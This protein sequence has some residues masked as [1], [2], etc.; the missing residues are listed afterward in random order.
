MA[1]W[2]PACRGVDCHRQWTG[3]VSDILCPDGVASGHRCP[4]RIPASGVS[5]PLRTVF[6]RAEIASR[7]SG[8]DSVLPL[9][10]AV[11][12]SWACIDED[13]FIVEAVSS[14]NAP[15]TRPR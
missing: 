2:L 12:T 6:D 4:D 9:P 8:P 3:N 1:A 7:N 10:W 13:Q 11:F 15:V 5:M 14:R